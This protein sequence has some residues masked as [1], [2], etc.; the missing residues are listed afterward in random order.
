MALLE[1]LHFEP[2]TDQLWL[3]GDLVN[4]GPNN[5]GVL[6]WCLKNEASVQTVLGNHDL[7]LM[8]CAVGLRKLKHLD[9]VQDVLQASNRDSL[10][11]YLWRQPILHQKGEFLMTH[12]GIPPTWSLQHAKAQAEGLQTALRAPDRRKALKELITHKDERLAAFTRMRTVNQAGQPVYGFAGSPTECPEGEVPWFEWPGRVR[13]E[14]T[15][16]VGHWAALG[17]RNDP[18]LLALDTG[19]VWGQS[20]TAVQLET[21]EVFSVPSEL[22]NRH[23]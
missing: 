19:C 7:H 22:E 15:L 3:T 1:V 5:V 23:E 21:R 4:R 14:A 6:R 16:I 13:I 8:A 18:Q 9:T 20:L 10:L 12:A 2:K 11:D 17:L